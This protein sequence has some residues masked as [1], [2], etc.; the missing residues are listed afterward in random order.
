M[1]VCM[2]VYL[3]EFCVCVC[4][5]DEG[6]RET[7]VNKSFNNKTKRHRLFCSK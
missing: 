6:V 4:V 3:Y 2:F 5:T 1:Y 7:G